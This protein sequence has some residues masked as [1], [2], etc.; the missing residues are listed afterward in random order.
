MKGRH[1]K[2]IVFEG[3]DGS[4][5][6]TQSAKYVEHLQKMGYSPI[7]LSFPNYE[8]D[9]SALVR[10]YL[11]GTFGRDPAAVNPFAASAFFAVDRIAGFLSDW[12]T[13]WNQTGSILIADRYTTSNAV[14]Q[15]CKLPQ[16]EW[17]GFLS[18]LYDF[19]YGKL[20]LP[21]PDAVIYLRLPPETSEDLLVSRYHGDQTRLDIH[22]RDMDYLQHARKAADYCA[23]YSH[24]I[25]VECAPEGR[26]RGID[27]I[28]AEIEK[29]LDSI[30][31]S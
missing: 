22:E 5:K 17:N 14:H 15:C 26:L 10:M 25:T 19:E 16:D 12:Q 4:G 31:I 7:L 8:S 29:V 18:W 30:L 2:L 3:L 1:G 6:A 11:S 9:S 24:W 20:G 21:S 23:G 13:V 27:D 28:A